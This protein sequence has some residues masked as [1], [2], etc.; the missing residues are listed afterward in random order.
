M[1]YG[2]QLDEGNYCESVAKEHVPETSL[3]IKVANMIDT[4]VEAV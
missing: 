1:I 3:P 4:V 2:V